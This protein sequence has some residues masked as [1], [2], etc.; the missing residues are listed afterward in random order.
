MSE[1]VKAKAHDHRYENRKD[2]FFSHLLVLDRNM[3]QQAQQTDENL[4]QELQPYMIAI[5]PRLTFNYLSLTMP[6]LLFWLIGLQLLAQIVPLSTANAIIF[7]LS[8]FMFIYGWRFLENRNHATAL[9]VLYTRYSRQRRDLKALLKPETDEAR[10]ISNLQWL[11]ES[12]QSFLDAAKEN[13][14][15]PIIADEK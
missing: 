15:E 4:F 9:F 5:L 1:S 6:L 2:V 3:I 11:A 8:L 12:A 10:L 14:L 7:A 13:G